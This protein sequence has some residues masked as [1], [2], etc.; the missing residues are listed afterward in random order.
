MW[1]VPLLLR[2]D[3]R[4]VLVVSTVDRRGDGA[5]CA[6]RAWI[7]TL[8]PDGFV[9]DERAD[10]EG[11]LLDH[12]PDFYAAIA[13]V[14]AD[15]PLP[16]PCF[17]GWLSSWAT[18]RAMQWPG[19][20][21]G[22]ISVPRRLSLEDRDGEPFIAVRP[23]PAVLDRLARSVA[24]PPR[25]GLGRAQWPDG[26]AR[27]EVRGDDARL[28]VTLS[29]E[30]LAVERVA[31]GLPDWRRQGRLTRA[32]GGARSLAIVVDAAT[33]EIFFVNEGVA[34]SVAMPDGG[35]GVRVALTVEGVAVPLV[36]TTRAP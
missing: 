18:A 15:W 30:L 13:S 16:H 9:P 12:G 22:P 20:A 3:G 25:S 4:D 10:V 33:V 28:D 14:D 19:F 32:G 8:A 34:I 6:V 24:D 17:V 36:W 5:D 23:H 27:L 29:D 1:E 7:G 31:A 21:G 26:T 35:R 2:V 11:Q